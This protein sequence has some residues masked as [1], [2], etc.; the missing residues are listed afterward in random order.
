MGVTSNPSIFE[1]AIGESDEY[2]AALKQ[3]QRKAIT[4]SPRSTS[5][6]RLPIFVTRPMCCARCTN[7]P[8]AVHGYISL[9]AATHLA[10]DTDAD[11]RRGAAAV[12]DGGASQSDGESPCY[13]AGVPAICQ[14]IGRGLNINITLLFSVSV[15][16]QVVEAISRLEDA[17]AQAA[18]SPRLPAS[19][20]SS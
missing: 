19:P 18:K 6:W 12:D 3:F 10:N 11:N 5:I 2:T 4:A 17:S 8:R 1:K 16:E 15:Y 9:E 14:L 20:V 13:E 7:R